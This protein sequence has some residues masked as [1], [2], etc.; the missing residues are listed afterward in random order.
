[1][2]DDL[3]E[4]LDKTRNYVPPLEN[5]AWTYGVSSNYFKNVINYWRNKY[6]WSKRQALLNK[7]PQFITTIQ[8]KIK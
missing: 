6:D 3:N 5:A 7:Y 8:G 4:R 1:M 2:I